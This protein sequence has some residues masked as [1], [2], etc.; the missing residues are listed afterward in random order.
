M[1]VLL[2][3]SVSTSLTSMRV[4]GSVPTRG[5]STFSGTTRGSVVNSVSASL[6]STAS[7]GS[8]GSVTSSGP[9]RRPS[10]ASRVRLDSEAARFTSEDTAVKT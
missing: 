7:A 4:R 1:T 3:V 8:R 6:P 10:T 2:K 9:S 5:L